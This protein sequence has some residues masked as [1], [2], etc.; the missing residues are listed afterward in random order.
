MGK[1]FFLRVGDTFFVHMYD[2]TLYDIIIDIVYFQATNRGS[3]IGANS[4]MLEASIHNLD[5]QFYSLR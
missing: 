4:M 2:Y 1:Q 5:R 3:D